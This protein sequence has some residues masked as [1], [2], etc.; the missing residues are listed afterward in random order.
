[1]ALGRLC[2]ILT[3]EDKMKS[4]FSFVKEMNTEEVIPAKHVIDAALTF[5]KK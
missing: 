2:I 5:Q 4:C 1:M 3:K